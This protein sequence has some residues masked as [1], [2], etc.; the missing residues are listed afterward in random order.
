MK[1]ENNGIWKFSSLL[2]PLLPVF[3]LTSGEGSTR[4]IRKEGIYFKCEF[5]NPTGSVKDRGLCF[6]IAKAK[7]NGYDRAVIS[8]SGNAA[9][10]ASFYTKLHNIL[11]TVFVSPKIKKSKADKIPPSVKV[12]TTKK[13]VS[14]A[15]KT[16]LKEGSYNLRPSKDPFGPVGFRTIS[17]EVIKD[18]PQA[19]SIF[20]PVSS[21]TT[22]LG[23]YQ[24][25]ARQKLFPAIHAVQT[26]YLHP[27]SSQFD[28]KFVVENYSLADA[29]VARHLPLEKKI[30]SVIRKTGGWG[31]TIGNRDMLK[32]RE[33]LLNYKLST[34][35]EGAACY[36]AVIKARENGFPYK[37]PVCLLTGKY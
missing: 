7:E 20:I 2:P 1:Q 17:F 30:I 37:N 4:L 34:S 28:R 13:P 24:G 21:G 31:W 33:K 3:Q 35:F 9:I 23:V 8:S 27:V 14:L 5:D 16:A 18:L 25:F 19:D 22:L 36:A 10:S 11:L 32:Y 12:V 15:H 29:L 6:Q 26:A